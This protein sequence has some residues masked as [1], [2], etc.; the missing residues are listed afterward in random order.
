M[1]ITPNGKK[2]NVQW[3]PTLCPHNVLELLDKVYSDEIKKVN[4]EDIDLYRIY[5]KDSTINSS[6]VFSS[7][8]LDYYIDDNGDVI[9]TKE[10]EEKEENVDKYNNQTV[11]KIRNEI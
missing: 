5:W 6:C 9:S 2:L 1:N 4:R 10:K 11:E 8:G 7:E 3:F